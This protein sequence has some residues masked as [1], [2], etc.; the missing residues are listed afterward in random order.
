MDRLRES[1]EDITE[2]AVPDEISVEWINGFNET[3]ADQNY[4]ITLEVE[5]WFEQPEDG[6]IDL[7]RFRKRS[8]MEV[9]D[10]KLSIAGNICLADHIAVPNG[11]GVGCVNILALTDAE[12]IQRDGSRQML[13]D[14][15]VVMIQ[16]DTLVSNPKISKT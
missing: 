1:H 3:Y 7:A 4:T 11:D 14:G 12:M 13:A 5:R 15:R 10:W 9:D 8:A 2:I 6:S 16:L